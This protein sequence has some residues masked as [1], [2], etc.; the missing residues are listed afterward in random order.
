MRLA[1]R[2]PRGSMKR[3]NIIQ[4]TLVQHS[5]FERGW[6]RL[7]QC[8]DHAEGSVEPICV[9]V[10]GESRTGK[11][12][13][14][15]E[16]EREHPRHRSADGVFVPVLRVKAPS[17]P[18][19]KGLAEVILEKL[20]D[21]IWHKDSENAKSVRIRRLLKEC[22]TRMVVIDE[23]QH[24]RDKASD[25]VAHH[26]ADWLKVL[27]DDEK[28]A[29]VVAGLPICRSIINQNEQLAG[30]FLGEVVM[31]RFDWNRES[32]REEFISI[33]VAFQERMASQ[34]NLPDF[35]E[36]W[37]FRFYCATGGLMGL[38]AKCLQQAAWDA[39]DEGR[40]EIALDHFQAA[41]QKSA[42]G[43]AR[44]SGPGPFDRGVSVVPSA[45]LLRRVAAIGRP[46]M[47]PAKGPRRRKPRDERLSQVLTGS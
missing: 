14:L 25:K 27:V 20:G 11:S 32:D 8:F 15:E 43:V 35:D 24:F 12:R 39:E 36:E 28:I 29:L 10:V 44:P 26:V 21:P 17:K 9:A 1:R 34:F 23:F 41:Y 47:D 37:A 45:D 7:I 3:N 22:R 5:A 42:W 6:A 33:V 30:R 38:L 46:V 40:T 4:A 2:Q 16:F 31:P 13:L 19:V 18:T